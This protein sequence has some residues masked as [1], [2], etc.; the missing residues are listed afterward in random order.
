MAAVE[1][2]AGQVTLA[3]ESG[4]DLSKTVEVVTE[5]DNSS[6][7]GQDRQEQA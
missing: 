7:G 5:M 3:F 6:A 1:G 4:P 2:A